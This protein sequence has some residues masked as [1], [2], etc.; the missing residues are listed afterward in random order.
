M[1]A[2]AEALGLTPQITW[3]GACDQNEVIDT[4]QVADLFVLPSRVAV[5]GDRDGLPNVLMEAASQMLPILSTPVSAIPEFIDDG[6]HGILSDDTPEALAANMVRL[7]Q[8][9]D[10][11][12]DLAKAAYKRLYSDFQMQ[13][14]I[15]HLISRLR[16]VMG[17]I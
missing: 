15:N 4:M 1:R 6:V 2:Q 8:N 13:P 16:S 7:A 14:G 11:S 17:G 12:A 5:D 3:L 10:F 9:P